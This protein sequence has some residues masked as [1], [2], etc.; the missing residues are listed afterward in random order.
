M[1][2][3]LDLDVSYLIDLTETFI[4]TAKKMYE[5]NTITHEKYLELIDKKN[6][7]INRISEHNKNNL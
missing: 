7:F 5:E 6:M 4:S 3:N 1:K 2:E